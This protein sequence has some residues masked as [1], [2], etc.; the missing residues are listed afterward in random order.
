LKEWD[1]FEKQYTDTVAQLEDWYG[2]FEYDT[3][4]ASALFLALYKHTTHSLPMRGLR[5]A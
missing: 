1:S 4:E 5:S 3:K 2:K